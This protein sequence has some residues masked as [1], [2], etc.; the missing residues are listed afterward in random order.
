MSGNTYNAKSVSVA[1]VP[2]IGVLNATALVTTLD[3]ARQFRHGR[4][5]SA[6]LGLV[7]KQHS[8]GGK[9]YS[10]GISKHGDAFLRQL[11]IHGARALCTKRTLESQDLCPAKLKR[12]LVDKQKKN[13]VVSVAMANRNARIVWAPLARQ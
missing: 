7:P 11:L 5:L 9:Q 2:G 12:L 3:N 13:N 10:G 4:Y 1:Q 8:N 6:F